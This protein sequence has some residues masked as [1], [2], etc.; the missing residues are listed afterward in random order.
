[1]LKLFQT[2]LLLFSKLKSNTS[3]IR[4]N[5]FCKF[6]VV[7]KAN[8]LLSILTLIFINCRPNCNFCCD[9]SVAFS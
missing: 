7:I 4:M 1:M 6:A 8:E 3:N 5:T 9:I 2:L